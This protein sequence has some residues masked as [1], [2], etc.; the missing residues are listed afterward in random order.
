MS[1][2]P[3]RYPLG[4]WDTRHRPTQHWSVRPP[5][6]RDQPERSP[7]AIIMAIFTSSAL[8][9]GAWLLGGL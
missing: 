4:G 5:L 2:P 7:L 3:P 8:I 1:C 9:I 6:E